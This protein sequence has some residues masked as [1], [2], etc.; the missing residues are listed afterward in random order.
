MNPL[1]PI[2]VPIIPPLVMKSS[3]ASASPGYGKFLRW[4][5][6]A[7]SLSSLV[8]G[9]KFHQPKGDVSFRSQPAPK[10]AYVHKRALPTCFQKWWSSLPSPTFFRRIRFT[11]SKQM[12]QKKGAHIRK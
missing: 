8:L 11:K 12:I 6:R 5:E 7:R 9:F 3:I 10:R 1:G 4:Y 2:V